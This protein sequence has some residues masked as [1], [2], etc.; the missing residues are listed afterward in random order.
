MSRKGE[1]QQQKR[2]EQGRPVDACS[3]HAHQTT[4]IRAERTETSIVAEDAYRDWSRV[5]PAER[6][7]A[8]HRAAHAK[9]LF[10][11]LRDHETSRVWLALILGV[12]E[13]QVRKMLRAEIP[14]PTTVAAC[15]PTSMRTDY[16]ERLAS[17]DGTA[18]PSLQ[19][20]IDRLD[21]DGLVA[22]LGLITSA[23]GKR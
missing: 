3:I 18:R 9:V 6:P 22:A 1:S 4:D 15:M 23:L 13:K 7:I 2:P 21:R 10:D 19:D 16:L 17:L 14:I 8:K 5:S 20:R 12:N 11:I